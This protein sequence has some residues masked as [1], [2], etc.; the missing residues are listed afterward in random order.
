LLK[1]LSFNRSTRLLVVERDGFGLRAAVIRAEK[2]VMV[3]EQV[4]VSK[5]PYFNAALVEAVEQIR[6][7]D[8]SAPRRAIMLAP[9]VVPALLEL[10]VDPKNPRPAAQMEEMIRWEMEPYLDQEVVTRNIGAILIGRG[11]LS[12]KDAQRVL[13]LMEEK[14][15]ARQLQTP[16]ERQPM[17]RFG[18][19]AIELALI[20]NENVEECL[21]IQESFQW[22]DDEYVCGWTSQPRQT[23]GEDEEADQKRHHWLAC[24]LSRGLRERW[25]KE[26]AHL[27]LSL[28][29]IYP[30]TACSAAALSGT[31]T[32]EVSAVLDFQPGMVGCTRVSGGT[33]EGLRVYHVSGDFPSLES[34]SDMV[35][36][37]VK[38]IWLSG[39]G[40]ALSGFA[41]K[42]S[43]ELKC[44]VQTIPCDNAESLPEK[45][46]PESVAGWVGALRHRLNQAG[47]ERAVCIPAADPPPPVH[48]RVGVWWTAVITATLLVIGAVEGSMAFRVWKATAKE[49][50][51]RQVLR[52]VEEKLD[53]I[54]AGIA[55][56]A[57]LRE[58]VARK[59]REIA[60]LEK[61]NRFLTN[62]LPHTG[63]LLTVLLDAVA[64]A[65]T[66][67]VV[68]DRMESEEGDE[69]E[70]GGWALSERAVQQFSRRLATVI[71]ADDLQV[72][73]VS[74]RSTPG[75]LGMR[76]YAFDLRLV[77]V[78]QETGIE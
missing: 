75:R 20:D 6:K 18:E 31:A 25:R 11:Y 3:I 43:K 15:S 8:K 78:K 68:I 51:I 26:F 77:P 1:K 70:M 33:I 60:V 5:L 76:G 37:R 35:G 53:A 66:K 23:E 12:A 36:S 73:D 62:E 54:N 2:K 58:Q 4:V 72:S 40:K 48:L 57:G 67:E 10:P 45:V 22:D 29:G 21:K 30:L 74:V 56:V 47:A 49:N 59:H 50:E 64:R 13:E 39:R 9:E 46:T 41:K 16:G 24:G 17:I 19:A 42:L 44:E 71:G 55:E 69:V 65:V 61:R 7:N 63:K 34:C 28:E 38:S 52:P 32:K 27:Q 14:K